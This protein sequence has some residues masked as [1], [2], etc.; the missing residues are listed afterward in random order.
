MTC[1]QICSKRETACLVL[2]Q[3]GT[4]TKSPVRMTRYSYID[5]ISPP[6][7][8]TRLILKRPRYKINLDPGAKTSAFSTKWRLTTAWS[9]LLFCYYLVSACLYFV[10]CSMFTYLRTTL[11]LRKSSFWPAVPAPFSTTTLAGLK[12]T[13]SKLCNVKFQVVK[14]EKDRMSE[15]EH[16]MP[17]KV[18]HKQIFEWLL[19]DFNSLWLLLAVLAVPVPSRYATA[20]LLGFVLTYMYQI[21]SSHDVSHAMPWRAH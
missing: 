20:S 11:L 19:L 7:S 13:F 16:D 12:H 5:L 14:K 9:Q 15:Q 10:Y 21:F 3:L 6:R 1:F 18:R 8:E 2:G 4:C 17:I